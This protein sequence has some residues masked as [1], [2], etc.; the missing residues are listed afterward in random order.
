MQIIY[1]FEFSVIALNIIYL[2]FI[3]IFNH[4]LIAPD[5]L[6]SKLISGEKIQNLKTYKHKLDGLIKMI[7]RDRMKVVFFGR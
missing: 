3:L 7:S 1:F 5:V 6:N 4:F 2:L